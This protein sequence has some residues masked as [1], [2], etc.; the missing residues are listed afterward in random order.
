MISFFKK[1]KSQ[2]GGAERRIF[3]RR[4]FNAQIAG[5]RLDAPDPLELT[6]SVRDLSL[7]GLCAISDTAISPGERVALSFPARGTRNAWDA[8]GRVIRCDPSSMGYR[9]AMEFDPIPIAA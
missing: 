2:A 5:Q 7:G 1:S 9:L 4:E 3:R 8:K 6:L